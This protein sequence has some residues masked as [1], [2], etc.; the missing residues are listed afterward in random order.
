MD[1]VFL[2]IGGRPHTEWC[3][4]EHVITDDR[5]YI[6]T[7]QD[8]VDRRQPS[9][10]LA[11]RSRSAPARDQP[12][13]ALRRG[14]CAARLDE[15]RRRG[16]RRGR[17]WSRRSSSAALPSSVSP[18]ELAVALEHA[19]E[20]TRGSA[21]AALRRAADAPG[22]AAAVAARL[23]S[24]P[25]R[26]LRGALAA[27]TRRRTKR[28][29]V[30]VRRPLRLLRSRTRRARAPADPVAASSTRLR[31]G[32]SRK[33][34]RAPPG[35]GARRRRSAARRGFVVGMVVQHE[36][37]HAETMA[38]TLALAGLPGPAPHG[39]PEVEASG[40]V[41]VAG[42]PFT[43]GSTTPGHTTTSGPRTSSSCRPFGSTARW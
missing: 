25:H 2:C 36:L 17:R 14:R 11:A 31:Q 29:V 3:S 23:G 40:E 32:G 12:R 26:L 1:G 4:R 27:A 21:G 24:R 13:R 34:A 18:S 37:Q 28:T 35:A 7:G 41:T 22:L 33:R 15:A 8:L 10:L 6:L 38:Q 39:P 43:L 30:G 20:R 19:R 5:G 9:R 16:R 42:G